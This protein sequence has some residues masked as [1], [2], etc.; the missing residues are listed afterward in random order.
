MC[1]NMASANILSR[2]DFGARAAVDWDGG[3]MPI[4]EETLSTAREFLDKLS[5]SQEKVS[6]FVRAGGVWTVSHMGTLKSIKEHDC[7]FFI[8]D[9]GYEL[10]LFPELFTE[11]G[12]SES[13]GLAMRCRVAGEVLQ[14][15]YI[16]I[17]DGDI[18]ALSLLNEWIH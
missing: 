17:A 3:S 2:I 9:K 8:P 5:E 15:V 13:G 7:Y 18:E 11:F 6:V 14:V 1:F 10:F 16:E 4:R 12:F